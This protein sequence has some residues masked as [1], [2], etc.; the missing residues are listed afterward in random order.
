MSFDKRSLERLRRSVSFTESLQ[1]GNGFG[2]P[3]PN[4]TKSQPWLGILTTIASVGEKKQVKIH[5]WDTL[6]NDK[7]ELFSVDARNWGHKVLP[8]GARVIVDY[9]SGEWLIVS[10]VCDN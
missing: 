7:P 5:T 3:T 8:A 9:V 2:A 10:A 6:T 4:G 1:R